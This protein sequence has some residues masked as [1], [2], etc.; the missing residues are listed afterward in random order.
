LVEVCGYRGDQ[1]C[2]ALCGQVVGE[3]AEAAELS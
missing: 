2:A 1:S 3:D